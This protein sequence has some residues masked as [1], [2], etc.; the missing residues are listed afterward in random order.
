MEDINK[1]GSGASPVDEFS[2]CH[3][4]ILAQLNSLRELPELLEPAARARRI[5]AQALAFFRDAVLEHHGQEEAE[6]FPAVLSS[7]AQGEERRLVLVMTQR[8]SAE[9]R[10]IEAEWA[11]LEPQ[12]KRVAKGQ[13]AALDGAKLQALV[14]RYVAHA[15]YEERSFLP[16]A[17]TVLGRNDD[18]MAA[19]GLS[20]HLRHAVPRVLKRFAGRV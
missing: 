2:S 10:S 16:L 20:L 14:D 12:L 7:A 3:E 19:L 6:L 5:A 13:D 17:K 1:S 15:G 18:H 4:G 9:H 11:A 8:L